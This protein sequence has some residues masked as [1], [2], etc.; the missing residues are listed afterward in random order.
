MLHWLG[1]ALLVLMTGPLLYL[2]YIA[3]FHPESLFSES[4]VRDTPTDDGGA[5]YAQHHYVQPQ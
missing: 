3:L 4:V 1:I 2:G 5:G